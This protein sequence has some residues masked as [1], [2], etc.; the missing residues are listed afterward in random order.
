MPLKK[1]GLKFC[2]KKKELSFVDMSKDAGPDKTV[3]ESKPVSI[4][5]EIYLSELNFNETVQKGL[6][7]PDQQYPN[8][9]YHSG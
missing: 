1:T 6:N 8:P 9:L 5:M 4:T 3:V 2:Q 7:S